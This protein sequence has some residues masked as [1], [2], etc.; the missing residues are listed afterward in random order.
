MATVEPSMRSSLRKSRGEALFILGG[1][2]HTL[3]RWLGEPKSMRFYAVGLL[4]CLFLFCPLASGNGKVLSRGQDLPEELTVRFEEGPTSA[5]YAEVIATLGRE[6]LLAL[7]VYVDR[8]GLTPA[9]ILAKTRRL[10]GPTIPPT[11]DQYLCQLNPHVCAVQNEGKTTRVLWKNVKAPPNARSPGE[12]CPDQKLP[13]YALCLPDVSVRPY[14]TSLI[15]PYDPRRQNL[16]EIVVNRTGGCT[17]LDDQCKKVIRSLNQGGTGGVDPFSPDFRGDLRLPVQAY[18]VTFPIVSPRHLDWLTQILDQLISEYSRAGEKL[19]ISYTVPFSRSKKQ[20]HRLT[21]PP[22]STEPMQ[23]YLSPLKVMHYPY[24]SGAD[25]H[26]AQLSSIHIGVWDLQVDKDHCDFQSQRGNAVFYPQPLPPHTD[27][28]IMPKRATDCGSVRKQLNDKYDH[29]THIAGVLAARVNE[30]GIAGVNPKAKLWAYEI[31]GARLEREG[32]PILEA[33]E[34]DASVS[35]INISQ[36]LESTQYRSQ[37]LRLLGADNGY[38]NRI[39][40]VAAA[41]NDG[42]EIST[43]ID[44]PVIPACWSGDP[45]HGRGIISVVALNPQGTGLLQDSADHPASNY[46]MAFD[47]A[48]VG[49]SIGTFHGNYFG[50]MAGTSVATPYVTGLASLIYAKAGPSRTPLP[51]EVKQRILYTADFTDT[52]D[53]LV[54]FGRINFRR[55]LNFSPDTVQIKKDMCTTSCD[56]AGKFLRDREVRLSKGELDGETVGTL[57]VKDIRRIAAED[58]SPASFYWIVFVKDGQLKKIRRAKFA[59][60]AVLEYRLHGG[61]KQVLLN[62]VKD[63][64]ACSI[65]PHCDR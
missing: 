59:E 54:R 47:V 41:G 10:V 63:Y 56:I 22:T 17:D 53:G 60:D 4:V 62:T 16:K 44:C 58:D 35:V 64:T 1:R 3:C 43:G 32:D 7:T 46:G 24:T 14:K 42:E 26:S 5:L 61:V 21:E 55:A 52:L 45:K 11:L 65:V 57:Q 18:S 6:D 15:R 38:Q 49:E 8:D 13:Q 9:E 29:A 28:P 2:Q 40:F 19:N 36:S 27:D 50:V 51:L 37:L 23:E 20:S 31:T 12:T 34:H 33:F 30:H 25:F 48:A 39:L